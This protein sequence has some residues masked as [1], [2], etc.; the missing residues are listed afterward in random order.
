[1]LRLG[2]WL[3]LPLALAWAMRDVSAEQVVAALR[4]LTFGEAV[5]LVAVN[6][7]VVLAFSGRWWTLLRGMGRRLPYIA[8]SAYRLAAFAVS[9]F[10]P[11]T[12]LGGEP[13]QVHLLHRR[14]GVALPT[15]TA[16]VVLDKAIEL[17]ANF[18]FLA[19]GLTTV[20]RLRVEPRGT[21]LLL[22]AASLLLAVVPTAYVVAARSGRRPGS[23]IV[24]RLGWSPSAVGRRARFV[25][26]LQ[27]SER[28]VS[29]AARQSSATLAGAAMFSVASWMLLLAEWVLVMRFLDIDLSPAEVIAVV[30][31]ARLALFVPLPGA[32]GALEA[33]L[34]LAL[35]R[36]GVSP[37]QALSLAVVIRIRDVIF[38][39]VGL[40]LGGWLSGHERDEAALSAS[41]RARPVG[42]R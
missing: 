36:L 33:S 32:A 27:A 2:L 31:A 25:T 22:E 14:H 39:G 3:A 8:L 20:V 17:I 35:T 10:T 6:I 24:T 15:A 21:T 4:E 5:L 34:V 16:A 12:H 38:G 18:A 7:F 29:A 1:V 13:L 19:I 11:G 37:A 26:W 42:E 41:D 23:W 28:E 30:T 9:Y 40:W